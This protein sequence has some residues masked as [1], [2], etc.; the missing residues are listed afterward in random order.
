MNKLIS[1]IFAMLICSLSISLVA[2]D[3]DNNTTTAE[4]EIITT[5][6]NTTTADNTTTLPPVEEPIECRHVEEIIASRAPTTTSVGLTEGKKCSLCGKIL[7]QQYIVSAIPVIDGLEY[8]LNDD[9]SSYSVI[10]IGNITGSKVVIPDKYKGL[11]VTAIGREAFLNCENIKKIDIPSGITYIGRSAFEGC[12]GL[13]E[14]ILPDTVT[15]MGIAVFMKCDGLTSVRLSK[16]LTRI[17]HY[18]FS[19]CENLVFVEIPDGVK[20]LGYSIFVKCKSLTGVKL[21][22][23]ISNIPE[24]TFFGCVSLASI[25]IPEGVEKIESHA[26]EN[27]QALEEMYIPSTLRALGRDSRFNVFTGCDRVKGYYVD[28]DNPY[29]YSVDGVL[30]YDDI[31]IRYPCGN[32]RATFTVPNGIV[33]IDDGAFNNC[34]YLEEV[35]LPSSLADIGNRVF[36]SCDN[37]KSVYIPIGVTRIWYDAFAKCPS[38]TITC[39]TSRKLDDWD[40]RWVDSEATVIWGR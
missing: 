12:S 38:L 30:Y 31:L 16:G 24:N 36:Y 15:E 5:V 18:T 13:T 10:G 25:T 8:L 22:T 39:A 27:C 6:S 34:E 35:I 7:K 2:C 29:F 28:P 20:E 21:P 9:G 14:I 32:E 4:N 17:E 37:L 11:P 23:G 19:Q 1:L 40:S 3:T 26:F 33:E